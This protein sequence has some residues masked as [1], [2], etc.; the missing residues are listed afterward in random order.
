L[1]TVPRARRFE[2]TPPSVGESLDWVLICDD[3]SK[4]Y[5]P[6]GMGKLDDRRDRGGI[7]PLPD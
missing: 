1:G 7:K 5:L 2:I 3:A 6:P 4:A